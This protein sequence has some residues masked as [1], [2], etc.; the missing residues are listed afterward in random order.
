[1]GRPETCRRSAGLPAACSPGISAGG[2]G[3]VDIGL[4]HPGLFGTIESWGGYFQPLRDG[5]FEDATAATLRGAT[6]RWLLAQVEAPILR[7]LRTTFFLSTG[8]SHSH[9][10]SA[11]STF[12]FAR[13]VRGLGLRAVSLWHPAAKGQWL[14]QLDAGLGW[15]L[16]VPGARASS[17]SGATSGTPSP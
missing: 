16:R 6:T 11:E 9:W 1:V 8:P 2:Y 13:E 12:A 7:R 15:A 17:G 10:F 14:S 5:P 3:A 4:R